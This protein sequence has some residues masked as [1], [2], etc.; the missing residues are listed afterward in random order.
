MSLLPNDRE[1]DPE[2]ETLLAHGR[3]EVFPAVSPG[4]LQ[5]VVG[6]Q[7]FWARFTD[8]RRAPFLR[9]VAYYLMLVAV[10]I[11]LIILFPSVR[12]A[13]LSP[14]VLP[15]VAGIEGVPGTAAG[16]V[17]QGTLDF[18]ETMDRAL[19]TLLVIAGALALVVPVARVY[20]M[21]KRF[22]FDPALVRSV[23]ILPIVVAGIA[24]V[25]KNSLALAFSLA[26]I[27]AAVRFR[28]TLKDPRDAVYIFLVIG[29]GLSAGVQALDVALV[30]SFAFNM[31]VLS[32][33][34]YN[35]G[36]IYGGRF[37]R[38]G[39]LSVGTSSLLVAQT[40]EQQRAVRTRHL[41][42]QDEMRIDGILLVHSVQPELARSTVQEALSDLAKDWRLVEIADRG[43]GLATLEYLV[44][45]KKSASPAELVGALDERWSSQ[46]TAAEYVPFRLR[47]RRR[48]KKGKKE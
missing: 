21:T 43:A 8:A 16:A 30:M 41:D 46:V 18:R 31:V 11:A 19:T 5:P 22:R 3:T 27:V 28:N 24:L 4:A 2:S 40:P 15:A 35:I 20:M 6:R 1:N 14:V 39:I 7:P 10:I 38:T 32:L 48:K 45:L 36:S 17:G 26:G 37:G 33:W 44:S 42:G 12:R 13:F 25:V 47:R 9:L 34:K 29:I 23:I